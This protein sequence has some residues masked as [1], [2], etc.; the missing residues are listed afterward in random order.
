M[1]LQGQGYN[2]VLIDDTIYRIEDVS[3]KDARGEACTVD[4][5]R[6]TVRTGD[7]DES[8]LGD[9]IEIALYEGRET[10]S[11]GKI[12]RERGQRGRRNLARFEA[13]GRLYGA[14]ARPL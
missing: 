7:E 10:A 6:L 12:A 4:V 9:S 13:D 8:R 14:Y 1:L 2:R 11:A 3:N 5:D